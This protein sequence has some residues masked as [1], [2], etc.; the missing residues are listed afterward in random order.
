MYRDSLAKTFIFLTTLTSWLGCSSYRV[1]R[2]KGKLYIG[3]WCHYRLIHFWLWF[4][5]YLIIVLPT[6]LYILHIKGEIRLFNFTLMIEG[7]CYICC[8][9]LG[10]FAFKAKGQCQLMNGLFI[11]LPKFQEKYMA[12][13]D[14]KKDDLQNSIIELFLIQTYGGC[15]V[16]GILAALDCAVRPFAPPYL[17]FNIDPQFVAWPWY[18]L[19][20]GWY[21]SFA[22]GFSAGT[23]LFSYFAMMYFAYCLPIVGF[24]LRLGQKFYKTSDFL[25]KDPQQLVIV[26]KSLE[27]LVKVMNVE[28][29]FSVLYIQ[30]GIIFCLLV[31]AVTLVYQWNMLSVVVRLMMAF[32]GLFSVLTFCVFLKLAGIQYKWS[33]QTIKSWRVEYF[34]KRIDWKYMERVKLASKPLSL[35]DGKRYTIQ[36][37]TVLKFLRSLSRN[38]FRALITYGKVMG[39][40]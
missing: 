10:V 3:F 17:L 1:D 4:A 18:V 30:S 2:Q 19:T 9:I 14:F 36:P 35:G 22:I 37:M 11:F 24:E 40:S 33:K 16:V 20:C 8:I 28:G 38:T 31:A 6:H 21:G 13:Y 7:G 26:W 39:Y 34:P 25:R 5:A 12:E 29:A 23:G 32:V 15:V 27:Y